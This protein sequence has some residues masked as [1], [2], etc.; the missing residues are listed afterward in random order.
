MAHIFF[1]KLERRKSTQTIFPLDSVSGL[2]SLEQNLGN[3]ILSQTRSLS[4][5][6]TPSYPFG[7]FYSPW[8]PYSSYYSPWLPF[9]QSLFPWSPLSSLWASPW[10]TWSYPWSSWS[11]PWSSWSYPW[12]VPSTG[13]TTPY[14]PGTLYGLIKRSNLKV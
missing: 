11:Y 9:G 6:F 1:K 10:S 8:S 7:T 5:F 12:S 14:P 2:E 4:Q 3:S 13:T